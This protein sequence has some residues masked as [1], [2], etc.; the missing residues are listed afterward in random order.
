MRLPEMTTRLLPAGLLVTTALALAAPAALARDARPDTPPRSGAACAPPAGVTVDGKGWTV[1]GDVTLAKGCSY[2]ADVTISRSN[3]TFDCNGATLDGSGGQRTAITI[4]QPDDK[5]QTNPPVIRDITVKNCTIRNYPGGAIA[6]RNPYSGRAKQ[7]S[8]DEVRE[9]SPRNV[10]IDGLRA[11]NLSGAGVGIGRFVQG[12]TVQNAVFQDISSPAIYLSPSSAGNTIRNSQFTNIGTR[13]NMGKREALAVDGSIRNTI[14]SNSFRNGAAGG[15]FLYKN[16]G[17]NDG[18]PRK[19]GA[20][21]NKITGNTFEDMPAAPKRNNDDKMDNP[22]GVWI[23]SRQ[24][25]RTEGFECSDGYHTV[26]NTFYPN[27][28][29]VREVGKGKGY[30]VVSDGRVVQT[31][32]KLSDVPMYSYDVA[33]DNVVEGNTFRNVA[34]GIRVEDDGNRVVNNRFDARVKQDIAVGSGVR[35]NPKG[36]N[37]PVSRVDV[38]DNSRQGR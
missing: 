31:L 30:E 14:T 21:G 7:Q 25:R 13:D 19:E 3:V 35:G 11:S 27:K 1:D 26:G 20:S 12:V 34:V 4:I 5:G 15:I 24:S 36:P 18:F 16:C 38:R 17:E 9:R 33:T 23:A 32:N 10:V 22:V 6:I 2:S 29:F 8:P 37:Q 28:A